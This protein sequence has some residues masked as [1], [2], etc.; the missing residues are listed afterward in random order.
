MT[1]GYVCPFF[2]GLF[3]YEICRLVIFVWVCCLN[4]YLFIYL[5]CVSL[6]VSAIVILIFVHV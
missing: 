4:I 6:Y 5:S 3:G 2:S 1:I